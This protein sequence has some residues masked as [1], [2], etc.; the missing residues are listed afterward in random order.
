MPVLRQQGHHESDDPYSP[1]VRV[2]PDLHGEKLCRAD[3]QKVA[4]CGGCC[5]SEEQE[6]E[7][8]DGL[9]GGGRP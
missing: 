6:G 2:H 9:P 7:R 1:R 4:Q 8:S 5:E 3:Q